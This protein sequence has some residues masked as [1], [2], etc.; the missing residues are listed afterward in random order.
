MHGG[1]A[2]DVRVELTYVDSE[3]LE[4]GELE[5]QLGQHDAILVPGGFGDRGTEGKI[6]AI[7]YAREH[8]VPFFGICLGMQMAVVEYA[9]HVCG[10]ERA[11]SA[12]FEPDA[13]YLVVD[14]MPDQRR[15]QDKGATMCD[16]GPILANSRKA[17]WLIRFMAH[18]RSCER[19][20]HP[21]RSEQRAPTGARRRRFGAQRSLA[22]RSTRRNVLNSRIA[23][24][25]SAASSIPS[26][27][28]SRTMHIRSSRGSC[29][30]RYSSGPGANAA[31]GQT[32][33]AESAESAVN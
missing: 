24:S 25:F 18:S 12:E 33:P 1:I 30:L 9:R 14:L 4:S 26:S 10:L 27:R 2:N 16:W 31:P 3:A 28:A 29:R 7:R 15:V 32:V 11:N 19:H 17:H 6:R 8:D 21:L 13:P 22:G 5:A 23:A 20:R